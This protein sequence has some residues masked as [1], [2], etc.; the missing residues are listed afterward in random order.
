MYV[1]IYVIFSS[2]APTLSSN[3]GSL[4]NQFMKQKKQKRI[5][6]GNSLLLMITEQ[7]LLP[8]TA[9]LL[10][11]LHKTTIINCIRIHAVCT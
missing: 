4:Y 3:R 2:I 9:S 5:A 10:I 8:V 1:L 7:S 6:I 11:T